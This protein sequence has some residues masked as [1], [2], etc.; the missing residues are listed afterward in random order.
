MSEE[1][2]AVLQSLLVDPRAFS[3]KATKTPNVYVVPNV[4]D[5]LANRYAFGDDLDEYFTDRERGEA[6][7]LVYAGLRTCRNMISYEL[8]DFDVRRR[9]EAGKLCDIAV[10][11]GIW[12]K[13]E[14]DWHRWCVS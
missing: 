9:E 12:E 5:W 2:C 4:R 1:I 8:L 13:I 3:Q 14:N 10:R 11:K 7:D 6:R